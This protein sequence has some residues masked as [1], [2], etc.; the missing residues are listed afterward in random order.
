MPQNSPSGEPAKGPP[1]NPTNN[2]APF[3]PVNKPGA[4]MNP[5]PGK[6]SSLPAN[7]IPTNDTMPPEVLPLFATAWKTNANAVW[8]LLQSINN[9]PPSD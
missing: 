7:W 4:V 6:P 1:M 2:P 9:N 8:A 5:T 3:N